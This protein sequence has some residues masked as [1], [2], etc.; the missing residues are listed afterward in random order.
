LLSRA[1]RG[2][3]ISTIDWLQSAFAPALLTALALFLVARLL[4]RETLLG[5]RS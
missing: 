2:D 5:A 1:L 3:A 4:G